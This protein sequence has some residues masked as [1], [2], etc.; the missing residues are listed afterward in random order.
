MSP[1]VKEHLAWALTSGGLA[2]L[3]VV[4]LRPWRKRR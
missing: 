1:H 2:L 3:V 4:L